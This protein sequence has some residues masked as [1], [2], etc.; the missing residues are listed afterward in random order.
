M[1][2]AAGLSDHSLGTSIILLYTE[3]KSPTTKNKNSK[4]WKRKSLT[5]ALFKF[6]FKYEKVI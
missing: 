2:R 5:S 3:L 6:L 1:G 4:L